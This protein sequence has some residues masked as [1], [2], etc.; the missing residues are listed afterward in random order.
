MLSWLLSLLLSVC[1]VFVSDCKPGAGLD[2]ERVSWACTAECCLVYE[3]NECVNSETW[4]G[5]V[6]GCLL[7]V[8]PVVER[9]LAHHVLSLSIY[10]TGLS[11]IPPWAT[12]CK[13]SLSCQPLQCKWRKAPCIISHVWYAP[14]QLSGRLLQHSQADLQQCCAALV[15]KLPRVHYYLH[16]GCRWHNSK[17]LFMLS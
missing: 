10:C 3:T 2:V 6:V 16:V 15:R 13:S 9:T 1:S 12:C 14:Q 7:T 4:G 8:V 5:V 17:E 11:L